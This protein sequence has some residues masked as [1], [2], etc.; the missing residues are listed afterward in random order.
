MGSQEININRKKRNFK[1]LRRIKLKA[2]KKTVRE[3]I[4]KGR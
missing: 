3:R 1:A 2:K 4:N